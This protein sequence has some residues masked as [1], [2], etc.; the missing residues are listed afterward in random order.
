M[1]IKCQKAVALL[2]GGLDSLLAAALIKSQE[3]DL[4]CIHF[5]GPF[6]SDSIGLQCALNF[7]KKIKANFEVVYM[8]NDFLQVI[9]AP[10]YGYGKNMNPC[11]DCRIFKFKKAAEI[12]KKQGAGFIVTGE[13]VGQRP[14][15]Q[16]FK[17]MKLIETKSGLNGYILRPLSAQKLEPT[18]P[19]LKNWVNRAKLYDISGRSRSIQIELAKR[20]GISVKEYSTPAGGCKLTMKEYSRKLDDLMKHEKKL[21]V[22]DVE[23]L[24]FGRHFR[25]SERF[26][27]IVGRN[28]LENSVLDEKIPPEAVRI[29]AVDFKGPLCFGFGRADYLLLELAAKICG[30]YCDYTGSGKIKFFYYNNKKQQELYTAPFKN[31]QIEIYRIN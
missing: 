16:N 2:S 23:L 12:M 11:I 13:V 20:Y 1:K 22:S 3:I 14:M 8:E 18:I 31:S 27:L 6:S 29:K 5:T 19:E 17:A 30:R 4:H 26:K 10:K 28:E 24:S 21:K 15:S 9:A 7:S 25:I